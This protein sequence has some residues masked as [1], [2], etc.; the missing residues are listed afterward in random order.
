MTF[1]RRINPGRCWRCPPTTGRDF[2]RGIRESAEWLKLRQAV[3]V[4]MDSIWVYDIVKDRDAWGRLDRLR[5]PGYS[6]ASRESGP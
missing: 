6:P 5:Y 2:T 3:V 1:I 4:L